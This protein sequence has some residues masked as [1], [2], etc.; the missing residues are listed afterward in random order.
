M[1]SISLLFILY[2][3]DFRIY[4]NIYYIHKAFYLTLVNLDYNNKRSPKNH[5]ILTLGPYR[6]E[7]ENI[8]WNLKP[9]M[10]T[11]AKGIVLNIIGRDVFMKAFPILFTSDMS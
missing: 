4:R 6:A 7:M 10:R 5:F 2:I 11:L 9:G 3:D 8:M 1:S